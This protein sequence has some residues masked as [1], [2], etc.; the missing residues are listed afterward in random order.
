MPLQD[1]YVFGAA[2][3]DQCGGESDEEPVLNYA[4]YSFK[5]GAEFRR[6]ANAAEGTIVDDVAAIGFEDRAV[7]LPQ[8]DGHVRVAERSDG[9]MKPCER[10]WMPKFRNFNRERKSAQPL[11]Q[12]RA[13]SYH[14]HP[15]PGAGDYLHPPQHAAA[16]LAQ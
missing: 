12:F 6:I 2:S 14:H 10:Q 4:G 7:P 1:L 8:N 11:H 15:L 13:V 5:Y 3:H 9:G 16:A